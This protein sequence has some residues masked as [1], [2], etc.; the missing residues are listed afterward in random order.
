MDVFFA[1]TPNAVAEKIEEGSFLYCL[2][3]RSYTKESILTI[4][5]KTP[6]DALM[7][8]FHRRIQSWLANN[9][10]E[11]DE[12]MYE[13]Y[14]NTFYVR[15]TLA[16]KK[17]SQHMDIQAVIH[18]YAGEDAL[19]QKIFEN[20]QHDKTSVIIVD[21][22]PFIAR[23]DII[24]SLKQ[25]RFKAKH[26]DE[27]DIN[28][29]QGLIEGYIFCNISDLVH[30]E[31]HIVN[32]KVLSALIMNKIWLPGEWKP[33]K[34][35]TLEKLV[36]DME[37]ELRINRN[38]KLLQRILIDD[39]VII[40]YSIDT[41]EKFMKMS[42][43]PNA[44]LAS[45][46]ALIS[47][48]VSSL[49]FSLDFKNN[50]PVGTIL[51][52]DAS[53]K[54]SEDIIHRLPRPVIRLIGINMTL[55][56]LSRMCQAS[57]YYNS[58]LCG[59]PTFWREKVRADYG[60]EAGEDPSGAIDSANGLTWLEYYKRLDT[61][62]NSDRY[63]IL[64]YRLAEEK[65]RSPDT[66]GI[67]RTY[68]KF[69]DKVSNKLK[70]YSREKD[71]LKVAGLIRV[72]AKLPPNAALDSTGDIFKFFNQ[73]PGQRGPDYVVNLIMIDGYPET[74]SYVNYDH[75]GINMYEFYTLPIKEF[76]AGKK[77]MIITYEPVKTK[78]ST[79]F[80]PVLTEYFGGEDFTKI[81]NYSFRRSSLTNVIIDGRLE[82]ILSIE[83]SGL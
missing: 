7:S 54:E 63:M 38:Y 46:P 37:D 8:I 33:R 74:A 56:S 61:V 70:E 59:D 41:V 72:K 9:K 58:I 44:V 26:L 15:K 28:D 76:L 36:T 23:A 55:E 49:I 80:K 51:T 53:Q 1:G 10:N 71:P 13:L 48:L 4:Y 47:A 12:N 83:L 42:L 20:C 39:P 35:L 2:T 66:K 29:V 64:Y 17:P 14:L 65:S 21:V 25:D 24:K 69:G 34:N 73:K 27:E 30:V 43:V 67:Y 11:E 82:R 50:V 68:Y 79:I 81:L 19:T 57:N 60:V 77:W 52:E 3:I 18:N 31:S 78:Y 62:F 45:D 22:K 6:Q 5:Y 32:V 75:R 40:H 16:A